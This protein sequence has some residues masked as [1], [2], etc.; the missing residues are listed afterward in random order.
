[1][2]LIKG[3]KNIKNI[4]DCVATIGNFDGLHIAHKKILNKLTQQAKKRNLS[5]MVISFSP[6]PSDFFGKKQPS[7]NSFV[8]KYQHLQKFNIDYFLIINFNSNFSSINYQDFINNFLLK[9]L[10]IKHLLIGDDF[11]FGRSRLGGFEELKHSLS[12]EKIEEV[13]LGGI[14]VSSSNI[15]NFLKNSDIISAN[16]MLGRSFSIS[17]KVIKGKQIGRTIGFPTANIFLKNRILP[18]NGVFA[19]DIIIAKKTYKSITNI[20]NRPT[21]NGNL[22]LV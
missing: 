2:Q 6:N 8:E 19:T 11:R 5:S 22:K 1:M 4:E 14:R 20:G 21:I 17:G 13:C 7:L 18:I 3:L 10:N 12:V 16:N 9:K 15:R